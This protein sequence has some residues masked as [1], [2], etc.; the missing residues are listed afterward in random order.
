MKLRNLLLT[1]TLILGSTL[2]QAIDIATPELN[3]TT[4]DGKFMV[5]GGYTKAKPGKFVLQVY[6]WTTVSI[7]GHGKDDYAQPLTELLPVLIDANDGNG[8]NP[9]LVYFDSVTHDPWG[10]GNY[11]LRIQ[12]NGDDKKNLLGSY[13]QDIEG[14]KLSLKLHCSLK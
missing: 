9:E 2:A 13:Y 1:F 11:A 10:N 6:E 14:E 7:K 5:L 3:C 12:T 8:D 4:P